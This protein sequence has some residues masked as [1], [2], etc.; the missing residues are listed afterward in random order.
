MAD[1]FS[2]N[3]VLSERGERA[4][5]TKEALGPQICGHFVKVLKASSIFSIDHDQ[6]KLAAEEFV[7]WVDAKLAEESQ[8]RF[9]LQMTEHNMFLDGKIIRIDQRS[10]GRIAPIRQL[11]LQAD[12]N[13]VIF[14]KG[15]TGGE[16][17]Q[18]AAEIKKVESG[19]R[20]SLDGFKLAH[21]ELTL[22]APEEQDEDE[23]VDDERRELIELYASLLVRCRNYFERI[24]HGA[25][26]SVTDI[27]RIVQQITDSIDEHGDI[28]VGLI[29]M[30]LLSGRDFVH[31][32]NCAVYS[33]LLASAVGLEPTIVVRCGMT[34]LAQDVDKLSGTAEVASEIHVGDET[35]FQT[36][37]ASVAALTQTGTRDV[38]S[39]LRLVT[40]YER[41][42]PYNRPLPSTWYNDEM[43]PH[44]LSRIVEIAR[45]YDILTQG[46][47][48]HSSMKPDLALQTMMQK[49]GSHY[50]PALMK[51]FVNRLGIFPV[52]TTVRLNDG[53]QALVIRSSP[54]DS[55][56]KLSHATR[57]TVRLLD[58]TEELVDLSAAS[59]K[60][61]SIERIL[62]DDEVAQRP[63]AFLLF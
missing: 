59:N 14:R 32:S 1:D 46:F 39:A 42:F 43:S 7:D 9:C 36:N 29:N 25:H 48:G 23:G 27:K 56:N 33:M 31:A 3:S 41:G 57:P 63:S 51:L 52:G 55:D 5:D 18:L 22:V 10:H 26:P 34:A 35:H 4:D 47:E 53:R 13:E 6:T 2:S 21:L 8:E 45:D 37:L 30:K 28:F 50:D 15:I 17:L 11:C 38:L 61:L 54:I 62:D 24:R 12:F 40:N 19:Q 16:M 60:G 49:M 58:G 44:L 20:D